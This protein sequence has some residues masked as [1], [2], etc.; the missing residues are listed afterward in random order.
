MTDSIHF[1]GHPTVD[2]ARTIILSRWSLYVQCCDS[3][4]YRVAEEIKSKTFK[5]RFL[6]MG[7]ELM[8]MM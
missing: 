6:G 8:M 5:N 1:Q 7:F 4:L 3:N 2:G